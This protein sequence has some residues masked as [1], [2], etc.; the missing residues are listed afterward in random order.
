MSRDRNHL[1]HKL[2]ELGWS[3]RKI[4]LFFYMVTILIGVVALNTR[5][6][7]KLI[8]IVLVFLIMAVAL[9]YISEKVKKRE[10]LLMEEN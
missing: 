3:Q 8:T 5:A 9:S 7:G 6:L 4:S 2:L 1:H 10:N